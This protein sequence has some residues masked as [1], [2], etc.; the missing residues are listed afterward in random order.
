MLPA[1]E[2]DHTLKDSEIALKYALFLP[3]SD[4]A[5]SYFY[6]WGDYPA[7]VPVPDEGGSLYYQQEYF[8]RHIF[9]ADYSRPFGD[10]VFR[11]EA[12]WFHGDLIP[13]ATRAAGPAKR[14][15]LKWLAGLD[16]YPGNNWTL[17][18]QFAESR[19][20]NPDVQG[21]LSQRDCVKTAT[22]SLSKKLFREKLT[23]SALLYMDTG[24]GDSLSRLS[25][26]YRLVDDLSLFFGSDI[27]QGDRDGSFGQYKD[28]TQVWTKVKYHF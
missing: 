11:A 22:L 4:L 8:R 5:L 17:S 1:Q 3:G 16:W 15:R 21:G 23:L 19:I 2:P 13:S 20:L 26:E 9:G 7:Q 24:M 12:A 28:N 6:T 27:F 10:F 18:V 25:S 14:D